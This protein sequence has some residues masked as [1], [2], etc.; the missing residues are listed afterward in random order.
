MQSQKLN[1]DL[2][3]LMH[4]Y[5]IPNSKNNTKNGHNGE[6]DGEPPT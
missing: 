1:K 5:Q 3:I 6:T 2:I 4:G